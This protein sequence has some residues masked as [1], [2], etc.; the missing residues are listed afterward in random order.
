MPGT[1]LITGGAGYIG[2]HALIELIAQGFRPIVFDNF[3]NSSIESIRRVERIVGLPITVVAADLSDAA[4]LD[5]EFE[6]ARSEGAPIVGV[7]HFAGLKAVGESVVDPM[8]YYRNNVGGTVTLLEA[9]DRH[10]VKTLIFSSSATVYGTPNTLPFDEYHRIAPTNPYGHSKAMVEQILTDWAARGGGRSAVSLRYFNPIGAHESGTIGEDPGQV[11]NN[12]FP[13]MTQVAV[14][15]RGHLPV[16]GDDYETVD[17][18]GVRDYVH[19]VDLAR[20]HVDALTYALQHTSH[21]V[22]N[23]GAGQGTS[24]LQLIKQFAAVTG[25]SVPY[26][27]VGRRPGDSAATYADASKAREQ[28]GWVATKTLADM[29]ADGW[30]WQAA[31]PQGY[32]GQDEEPDLP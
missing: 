8:P 21:N 14:G 16:F 5:R 12:L 27:V 26:T 1:L 25:R 31:N 11:P 29:C 15:L 28:L 24:V 7:V 20:G 10:A 9:M 32:R 19:V 3:S 4:E 17:G 2:T 22:F 23:L 6:H 18:T 30:R 13:F